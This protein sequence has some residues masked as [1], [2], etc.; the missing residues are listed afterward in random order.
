MMFSLLHSRHGERDAI[1]LRPRCTMGK[2]DSKSG[3][4]LVSVGRY[5]VPD[6]SDVNSGKIMFTFI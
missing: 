4:F 2:S 3:S 5:L 6:G 1:L